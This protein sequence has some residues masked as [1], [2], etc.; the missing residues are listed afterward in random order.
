MSDAPW[1]RKLQPQA[2]AQEIIP[3][4]RT[5]AQLA[6]L[7]A[8]LSEMLPN[9]E[10]LSDLGERTQAQMLRQLVSP[11]LSMLSGSWTD[12]KANDAAAAIRSLGE[13]QK[14]HDDYWNAKEARQAASE[15]E[16]EGLV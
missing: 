2:L 5:Q 1:L 4:N 13:R 3:Q 9:P 6:L 8:L 11:L 7:Q 14:A 16:W 12:Q 15:K 10:K